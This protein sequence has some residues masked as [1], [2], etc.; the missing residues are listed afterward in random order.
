MIQEKIITLP[1]LHIHFGCM[2]GNLNVNL[3][4]LYFVKNTNSII[5]VYDLEEEAD[6]YMPSHFLIGNKG[7]CLIKFLEKELENVW[8]PSV[9]KLLIDPFLHDCVTTRTEKNIIKTLASASIPSTF[10]RI[11]CE[12]KAQHDYEIRKY[13]K[14]NLKKN[15]IFSSVTIKC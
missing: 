5:P 12:I 15:N 14:F 4:Y 9:K 7:G 11:T 13:L 8:I 3:R 10:V 2:I 6:F 1:E